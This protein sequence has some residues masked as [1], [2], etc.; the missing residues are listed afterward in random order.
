MPNFKVEYY[1]KSIL[2]KEIISKLTINLSI[3][4]YF[5]YLV[6]FLI[7]LFIGLYQVIKIENE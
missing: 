3:N 2:L 5:S 4:I 6:I 1:L 7:P